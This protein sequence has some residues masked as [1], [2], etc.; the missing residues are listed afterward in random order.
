M[1]IYTVYDKDGKALRAFTSYKNALDYFDSNDG[2]LIREADVDDSPDPKVMF[3]VYGNF[4][5]DKYGKMVFINVDIVRVPR[6]S[7]DIYMPDFEKIKVS[8][9]K[10]DFRT[11]LPEDWVDDIKRKLEEKIYEALQNGERT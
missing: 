9:N 8:E 6:G 11:A 1:T 4:A 7:C 3:K 2:N 10:I 5:K